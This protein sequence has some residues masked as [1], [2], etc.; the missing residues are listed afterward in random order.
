MRVRLEKEH[1]GYLLRCWHS[2]YRQGEIAYAAFRWSG[3]EFTVEFP[4]DWHEH[5]RVWVRLGLIFAKLAVSFPWRGKVPPD[6]GQCSGP[7]YGFDYHSN[8]LWLKY[9]KSKGTR[10]D[11]RTVIHMPWDWQHVRHSYLNPD[12]SLHHHAGRREYEVPAGTTE[13]HPYVYV[14]RGGEIQQRSATV[15]GEER[16]WRWRAFQWFPWPRKIRRTINVA[17][18]DEVGERT[19]S[20]K[21]GV[22]GTGH[23]WHKGETLRAALYRMQR[24][25]VFD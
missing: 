3:P 8:A 1:R 17:F 12:G 16:E 4:S 11:P 5:R 10:D 23:D 25:R 7:E 24:E 18:S 6:E 2:D 21:G 20:W 14:R 15:N 19:G 9:G 22:L 13:T